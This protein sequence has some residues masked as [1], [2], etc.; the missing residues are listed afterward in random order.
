MSIEK[1]G[2]I[3]QVKNFKNFHIYVRAKKLHLERENFDVSISLNT[4]VDIC[5]L[6]LK[7]QIK[8][9]PEGII[10]FDIHKHIRDLVKISSGPL[11]LQTETDVL[12]ICSRYGAQAPK[13][14]GLRGWGPRSLSYILG[15]APE[16]N[17]LH[18]AKVPA[19]LWKD[20][21]PNEAE[22]ILNSGE[23]QCEIVQTKNYKVFLI[24]ADIQRLIFRGEKMNASICFYGEV[25]ICDLLVK[26]QIKIALEGI[27]YVDTD[28]PVTAFIKM[29]QPWL[30]FH[31][32]AESTEIFSRYGAHSPQ[33]DTE[34]LHIRLRGPWMP[35]CLSYML[36]DA[37]KG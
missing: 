31:N 33:F 29:W 9:S 8:L 14:N 18:P 23:Q 6:V 30:T 10:F 12:K 4:E 27:I 16:L 7:G 32:Q 22:N 2:E 37:P 28:K 13:L 3:V 5:D 15:D 21:Y 26:G 25:D 17:V 24:L 36:G 20:A 19:A 35:G 11:L 34:V 1:Q